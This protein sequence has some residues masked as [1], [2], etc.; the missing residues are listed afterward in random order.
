[1][2]LPYGERYGGVE[3]VS[4]EGDWYSWAGVVLG[5]GV[6]GIALFKDAMA[7]ERSFRKMLSKL[8]N[9]TLLKDVGE[10]GER[11][12]RRFD[13]RAE[14]GVGREL[15]RQSVPVIINECLV[16]DAI[17]RKNCMKC[18]RRGCWTVSR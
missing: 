10:G 14:L 1:M 13:L 6:V 9:G 7:D 17:R 5:E 15:A 2:V 11:I 18:V 4:R 16:C 8:F 3:R 12:Y